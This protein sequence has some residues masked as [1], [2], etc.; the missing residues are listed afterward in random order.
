[1]SA[2]VHPGADLSLVNWQY[3][4]SRAEYVCIDCDAVYGAQSRFRDTE[5][6]VEHLEWWHWSCPREPG[7]FAACVCAYSS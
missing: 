5:E 3:D 4:F 1:M 6:L 2:Q 7:S